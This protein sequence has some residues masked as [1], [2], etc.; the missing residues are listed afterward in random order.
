MHLT[1]TFT[2]LTPTSNCK[3]HIFFDK[4]GG[5]TP[6]RLIYIIKKTVFI[7]LSPI[8]ASMACCCNLLFD[9]QLLFLILSNENFRWDTLPLWPL[10]MGNKY[11]TPRIWE[12]MEQQTFLGESTMGGFQLGKS[13]MFF[14]LSSENRGT[15]ERTWPP[16]FRIRDS[17]SFSLCLW[18]PVNKNSSP[19]NMASLLSIYSLVSSVFPIPPS[20]P[21]KTHKC[22]LSDGSSVSMCIS[23]VIH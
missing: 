20:D 5:V 12:E 13:V 6:Y 22:P 11:R 23:Q 16:N 1:H 8:P 18:N 4:T 19:W 2:I 9:E 15:W 3:G 21:A 10:K 17:I 14:L 7:C